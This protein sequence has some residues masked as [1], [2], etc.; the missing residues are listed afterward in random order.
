VVSQRLAGGPCQAHGIAL[1]TA[2][3]K[4]SSV[5]FTAGEV[6]ACWYTYLL[7]RINKYVY[8]QAPTSP[9]VDWT[10]DNRGEGV[11]LFVQAHCQ[12]P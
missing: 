12:S 7:I 5:Q 1:H 11:D 3:H 6:G 8:Q 2:R 10:T 9:A 4:P